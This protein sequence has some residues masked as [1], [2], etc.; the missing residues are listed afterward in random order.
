[1]GIQ[2]ISQLDE[3]KPRDFK[4]RYGKVSNNKDYVTYTAI[5]RDMMIIHDTFL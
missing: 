5:L 1:M 3:I 2:K 4:E